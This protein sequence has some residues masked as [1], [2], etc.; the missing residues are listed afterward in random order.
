VPVGP[1]LAEDGTVILE[2]HEA[3]ADVPNQDDFWNPQQ[4]F[5]VIHRLEGHQLQTREIGGRDHAAWSPA[6]TNSIHVPGKNQRFFTVELE[7]WDND[8]CCFGNTPDIFDI[9]PESAPRPQG[10]VPVIQYDVCTGSIEI[11]SP[12]RLLGYHAASVHGEGAPGDPASP[13]FA[14]YHGTVRFE[15]RQEPPNWLPDDVAIVK[16]TPVQAVYDPAKIIEMKATS[17]LVEVA[18]SYPAPIVAPVTAQMTDGLSVAVDSRIVTIQPGLTRVVLFDGTNA[19]PYYPQK[20]ALGGSGTLNATA[21]VQYAET[22]SPN[23]PPALMDCANINNTGNATELPIVRTVDP[24]VRFLRFDYLEDQN[25]V[26]WPTLQAWHGQEEGFRLAT[27]PLASLNTAPSAVSYFVDHGSGFPYFEPVHSLLAANSFASVSGIDK[28]VLSVR[29]G[30][31]AENAFRHQFISGGSIGYSLGPLGP[32]AVLAEVGT[33][34]TAAHELGHTFWM[35]QHKCDNGGVW[36]DFFGLSCLD[37][38]AH[39]ASSGRP[40]AAIGYDVMGTVYPGGYQDNGSFFPGIACPATT[41]A[42]RDVCT[43]NFMDFNGTTGFINWIDNLSFNY[44]TTKLQPG[45]DPELI[46]VTGYLIDAD[47][48]GTDP[49]SVSLAGTL[50]QFSYH[51]LGV[52]DLPAPTAASGFSGVGA[53]KIRLQ[54][55]GGTREYRFNPRMLDHGPG[56]EDLA[57]FAFNIPWDPATQAIELWKSDDLTTACQSAV[58]SGEPETMLFRRERSANPP[59]VTQLR[60][61]RNVPPELTGE[62]VVPTIGPGTNVVLRWNPTDPDGGEIRSLIII[63]RQSSAGGEVEWFPAGVDIAGDTATV[64]H[65]QLADAAGTYI[66]RVLVSDGLDGAEVQSGPL[67]T[68][69]NYA[70]Q[71]VEVCNG[72]DDDCDGVL[73]NAVRPGGGV[74]VTMLDGSVTWNPIAGAETYDVVRGSGSALRTSGSFGDSL[75]GCL[76]NDVVGTSV[77]FDANPPS[78]EWWW[79]LVRASNCAGA[80]TYGSGPRDSGIGS[81]ATACP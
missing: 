14:N 54:T 74:V 9:D 29:R 44:L 21:T 16:V 39:S 75:L 79:F 6:E 51:F 58:C 61:G 41:P 5:Y 40:Y 57:P 46:N 20:S 28:V 24:K 25:T 56:P 42:P 7:L 69:C 3:L 37:E 18:S 73:D 1:S 45:P 49:S 67:F 59:S 34:G 23:A 33:F 26:A 10:N 68:L 48:I 27:W 38:Y 66:G 55:A 2:I 63:G 62:P 17:L 71:G 60:A 13:D 76:G 80:G 72:I 36:E 12:Y 47:G 31:F 19:P 22:L 78:G 43:A 52:E 81:N 11:F 65:D 8:T 35:S 4:D 70:N 53:F 64:P 50:S 15:V 32:R 30:W 77:P